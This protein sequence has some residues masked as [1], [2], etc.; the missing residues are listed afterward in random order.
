M[1]TKVQEESRERRKWLFDEAVH[2]SEMEGAIVSKELLRDG[3]AYVAG[4][5]DPKEM[6]AKAKARYGIS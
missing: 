4:K 5:V 3:E 1:G 2:S 6:L